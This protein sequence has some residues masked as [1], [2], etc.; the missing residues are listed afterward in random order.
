M[1]SAN[2]MRLIFFID[3]E[4]VPSLHGLALPDD[5]VLY[6]FRGAKQKAMDDAAL[7]AISRLGQDRFRPVTIAGE[8]KNALDFHIAF[9]VGEELTR[10]V[11]NRCLIV[12]GDRGFDP[13][14]RHLAQRGF[15]VSRH[16][17]LASAMA[18][19][20]AK[21][22]DATLPAKPKAHP[23]VEAAAELLAQWPPKNRPRTRS[24]LAKLLATHY[25]SSGLDAASSENLVGE[26]LAA[27]A[28]SEVDGRLAFRA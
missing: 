10:S 21:A 11:R 2:P 15:S 18:A 12:S 20:S 17:N 14:V 23:T 27:G 22:S 6:L 19:A 28:V 5:A 4:N 26:L 9:Y 24:G 25:K 1:H 16:E 13:L 8:G 3:Y 7:T